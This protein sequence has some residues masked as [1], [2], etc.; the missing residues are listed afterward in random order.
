MKNLLKFLFL[1]AYTITIFFID[2]FFIISLFSIFNIYLII[3][4]K[5]SF[6]QIIRNIFYVSFFIIF[7]VILNIIFG[8]LSTG[9]LTGYK[10]LLV[11][12]MTYIFKFI[13]SPAKISEAIKLLATPLKIFRINPEDISL[14]INIAI[15]FI[16][17]LFREFFQIKYALK[18]KGISFKYTHFIKN[19]SLILKILLISIFQKT[20]QLEY[21]IK[22]KG[23]M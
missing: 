10:L 17:I 20:Y 22:E 6:T 12:N 18:A 9:L 21:T 2:D 4:K 5:I 14:I 16:P 3:L 15:A 11:C 23:Y 1:L 19:T 13:L 8:D 7:T